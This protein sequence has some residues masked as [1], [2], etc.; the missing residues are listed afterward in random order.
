[1]LQDWLKAIARDYF[2]IEL[3]SLTRTLELKPEKVQVRL[4]KSRW[5][6]CSA[7]GTLSL[8]GALMLRPPAEVRYVLIHELCHLRHMN[9]SKRFWRLVER[10]EPDY[11]CLDRT[12]NEAWTQTPLW[13]LS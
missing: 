9:H 4:Q 3:K 10:F 5:G 1:L 8:N 12:L 2:S 7:A 13:L 11:R 6:S